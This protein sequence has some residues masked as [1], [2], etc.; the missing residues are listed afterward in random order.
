[1]RGRREAGCYHFLLVGLELF[2]LLEV[3]YLLLD[4]SFRAYYLTLCRSLALLHHLQ[5]LR[6][7]MSRQWHLWCNLGHWLDY[8]VVLYLN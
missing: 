7:L 3:V 2:Q 6:Q 4:I 8:C 1:M 5:P